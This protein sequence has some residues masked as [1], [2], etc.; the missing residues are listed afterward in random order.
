MRSLT[1]VTSTLISRSAVRRTL[2]LVV[3]I[4]PILAASRVAASAA[5]PEPP[6]PARIAQQA[7]AATAGGIV[8]VRAIAAPDGA[9]LVLLDGQCR[10]LLS[11]VFQTADPE[12]KGP[13]PASFVLRFRQLSVPGRPAPAIL[14]MLA[15]PGGSDTVFQT[16]ILALQDGTFRLALPAPAETLI[17]GG[18]FLGDLGGGL[19]AGFAAWSI[20]WSPGET[21]AGPHRY[22]LRRWRW[23]EDGFRPLRTL[24]TRMRFAKPDR[25]LASL[26]ARYRDM[27]LDFPEFRRFR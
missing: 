16:Q 13:V 24:T 8:L 12:A 6:P 11:T 2:R 4:A 27:T 17:E 25:A 9:R 18:V 21:H 19:G 23:T 26:G 22:A 15:S 7:E 20:V 3:L 5:C 1:G 10:A 14:T